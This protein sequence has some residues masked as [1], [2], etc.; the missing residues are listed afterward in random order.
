MLAALAT[1]TEADVAYADYEHFGD[2]DYADIRLA[3]EPLRPFHLDDLLAGRTLGMC[4]L[5]RTSLLHGCGVSVDE[6]PDLNGVE[7]T[8]LW[9]DLWRRAVFVHIPK[10]LGR[11]RRHGAQLTRSILASGGYGPLL[12]RARERF[13]TRTLRYVSM[14]SSR[15]FHSSSVSR[16]KS[17]A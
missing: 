5:L 13:S 15:A 3:V 7:D 10:S 11:Y 16:L 14:M 8:V 4:A 1:N 17:V 2:C 12:A 9:Q 6:S